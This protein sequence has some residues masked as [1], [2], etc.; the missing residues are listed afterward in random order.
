MF[1]SSIR[2]WHSLF[3]SGV[4]DCHLLNDSTMCA[5]EVL[6]AGMSVLVYGYGDVDESCALDFRDSGV[7]AFLVYCDPFCPLQA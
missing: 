1:L 5:I 3:R 6:I 2:C 7:C 4:Y